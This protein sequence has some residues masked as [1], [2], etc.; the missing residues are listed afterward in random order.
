MS[1]SENVAMTSLTEVQSYAISLQC[2]TDAMR[3]VDRT[4]MSFQFFLPFCLGLL[5][6]RGGLGFNMLPLQA[7]VGCN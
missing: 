3:M 7:F 5:C 2:T 6:P 4:G 1:V